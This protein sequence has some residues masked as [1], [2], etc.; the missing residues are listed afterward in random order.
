MLSYFFFIML[1]RNYSKTKIKYEKHSL[2]FFRANNSYPIDMNFD[3]EGRT[4]HLLFYLLQSLFFVFWEYF[5]FYD[6]NGNST[7]LLPKFF[8]NFTCVHKFSRRSDKY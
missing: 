8:F 7:P 6:K 1:A 4:V 3:S 2:Y 5:A